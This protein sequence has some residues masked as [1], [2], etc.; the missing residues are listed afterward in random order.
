MS[1]K[2]IKC[3]KDKVPCRS[4]CEKLPR[5]LFSDTEYVWWYDAE[6]PHNRGWCITIRVLLER[7]WN[8]DSSKCIPAPTV[9]ELFEK[10]PAIL[11]G[12]LRI[13][14]TYYSL[15]NQWEVYAECPTW[16]S[17][18]NAKGRTFVSAVCN[19]YLSLRKEFERGKKC[20]KHLF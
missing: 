4:L 20:I 12:E 1:R 6:Y 3:K 13:I 2:W 15:S 11:T 10:F 9:D 17:A 8:F 5:D 18:V 19:L 16:N 14:P 7:G